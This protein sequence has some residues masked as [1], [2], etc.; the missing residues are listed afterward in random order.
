MSAPL[1]SPAHALLRG[2]ALALLSA[3]AFG[4]ATPFIQRLSRGSG[5]LWAAGLLY[6]GAAL[7]SV[8]FSRKSRT[9]E[10]PVRGV[11]VLRL[12]TVAL[13][14]AVLAPVC[15]IWGLQRT[16][17]VSASLLLNFEAAFTVVLARVVYREAIGPR[18]WLALAVISV[19]GLILA[20]SGAWV[21]PGFGLGAFAIV[22]ATLG[23]ALDNTL[24]RPLAELNPKQVVLWKGSLGAL[25][26]VLLAFGFGELCPKPAALLGLL[27]C[28]ATGYGFSLQLYLR[29]QRQIGAARTGSIFAVAPFFGATVAWLMGGAAVGTWAVG[30]GLCFALGVYLHLTEN[31]GHWHTHRALAHDH[32]HRHDDGHHDHEHVPPVPGEHSHSH[33]HDERS[34]DHAHASDAHHRHEH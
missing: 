24:S 12:L 20:S 13:V 34:H 5:V 8:E 6:A 33:A 10:A 31:H 19:G 3:L 16:D 1:R 23:W 17:A 15:L 27:A 25:C 28:G 2:A 30:A 26:S 32:V 9:I 4:L 21:M 14:G 11:H 7:A 18:V 22:L 29:A